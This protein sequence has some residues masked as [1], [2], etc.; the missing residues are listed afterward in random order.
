[1]TLIQVLDVP[2]GQVSS[3]KFATGHLRI[4]G[5]DGGLAWLETATMTS[6]I[7]K[8]FCQLKMYGAN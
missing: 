6:E 2:V 4:S 3:D 1:M 5:T 7:Q 8:S